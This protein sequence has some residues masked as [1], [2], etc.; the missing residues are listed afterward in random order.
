MFGFASTGVSPAPEAVSH[1]DAVSRKAT[2]GPR[3][4]PAE[5][6]ARENWPRTTRVLPWLLAAFL[7]MVFLIPF[8]AIEV[9]FN[10]PM[11]NNP[12]RFLL[13]LIAVLWVGALIAAGPLRPRLRFSVVH[14]AVVFLL[15]VAVLSVLANAQTLVSLGQ[16]DVSAKKLGILLSW[17]ALFA[18]VASTI[19]PREVPAF[20]GLIVVLGCLTALGT[21]WEYR[22][23]ENLFYIWTDAILPDAFTVA[24]PLADPQFGRENVTGPTLHPLGVATLLAMALPFAVVGLARHRWGR[25][26]VFYAVATALL[27]AGSFATVRRTG[28]LAPM[29]ALLFMFLYRPQS[30]LRILPVGIVLLV[31]IQGLSP[32]AISRVKAQVVNAVKGEDR[33]VDARE[34]DYDAVMPDVLD[35]IVIGRGYGSYDP[36]WYRYLD[37]EYLGRVIETGVLG[38]LAYLFVVLAVVAVAHPSIRSGDPRRAPPA[39]AVAAAAVAF[40]VASA[41]F[42]LLAFSHVPYLFFFVAGLAVACRARPVAAPGAPAREQVRERPPAGGFEPHLEPSGAA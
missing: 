12:D 8:D 30:M 16:F 38:L 25:E 22:T 7:A 2:A 28:A 17:A 35:G 11:D 9:P 19:R 14:F 3:A 31:A 33:S 1:D 32:G 10:L 18:I 27:L 40:G 29:A 37:N 23:G 15:G 24:A 5:D 20:A 26:K 4:A 13:P 6:D 34:L 41:F 42:D 21:I 36:A 39:L